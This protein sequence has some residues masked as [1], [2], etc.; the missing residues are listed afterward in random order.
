MTCDE[1]E[2]END[3]KSAESKKIIKKFKG[4]LADMRETNEA[5]SRKNS[6]TRN[7]NKSIARK[8][9]FG[10]NNDEDTIGNNVSDSDYKSHFLTQPSLQTIEM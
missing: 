3:R 10:N 5:I 8:I 9:L 4:V 6:N 7:T 1:N 2:E